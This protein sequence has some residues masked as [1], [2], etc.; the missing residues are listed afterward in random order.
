VAYKIIIADDHHLLVQGLVAVLHEMNNIEV[1]AT[2]TNGKE[3]V[4]K[5]TFYQ[6]HLVV[7]DLNMPG[8][9]GINCLRIIK[10]LR[11]PV[12]VL[13]LTNYNQPELIDHVKKMGA[14]GFMT[15][16]TTSAELKEVISKIL[17]GGKHFPEEALVSGGEEPSFFMDGFLKKHQ[18]T[19]REVAIIK[20][21]CKE[22][23]SKDIANALFLSELTVKTHRRNIMKKPLSLT[24]MMPEH[25]NS[26][27]TAL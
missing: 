26:Y 21:I 20:M 2:V 6:P 8:N 27:T 25:G 18:L 23:S 15:K 17:L 7:L 1:V 16:N 19:R 5:V 10:S 22:M 24:N 13:V 3:V 9:D 14:E 4:E 11:L 12:K